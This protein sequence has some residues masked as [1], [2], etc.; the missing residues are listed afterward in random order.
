MAALIL[1]ELLF[2]KTVELV[3]PLPHQIGGTASHPLVS[4]ARVG[5]EPGLYL[6]RRLM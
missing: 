1:I 2:G 4:S 5:G 3:Q 6:V